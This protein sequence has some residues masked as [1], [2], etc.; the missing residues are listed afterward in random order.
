MNTRKIAAFALFAVMAA[1][2]VA[3]AGTPNCGKPQGYGTS[4]PFIPN[5]STCG[6]GTSD[7]AATND[8]GIQNSKPQGYGT[9]NP[10][11][12]NSGRVFGSYGTRDAAADTDSGIHNGKPQGYG[13]SNPYI[14]NS[15]RTFGG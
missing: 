2:V 5:S 6:F 13:T 14:F 9:N 1:P 7:A 12:F 10:Y 3:M 4:N 11:V 15:G 8:Y